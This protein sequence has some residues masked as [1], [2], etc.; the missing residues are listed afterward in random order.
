[1]VLLVAEVAVEEAVTL[2]VA[3]EVVVAAEMA[4]VVV[5]EAEEEVAEMVDEGKILLLKISEP[6]N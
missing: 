5:E 6:I 1:M 3:V 4:A 2:E